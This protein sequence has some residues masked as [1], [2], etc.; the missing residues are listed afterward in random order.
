[1]VLPRARRRIRNEGAGL[2]RRTRLR[3]IGLAGS[4]QI[5]KP[6]FKIP[7]KEVSVRKSFIAI[8]AI[9]LAVTISVVPAFARGPGGGH[10]GG[11]GGGP[12][13]FVGASVNSA[14]AWRGSNP[15]GF[16]RGVKAG[17]DDESVPPGWSKGKKKGW[18]N[19][20]VPPG[21]YRR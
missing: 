7:T 1:V 15:P 16:S 8:S 14:P 3:H 20:T 17:W 4:G 13:A 6:S 9:A 18:K 11:I 10:G 2:D 19:Q 21:L 5:L 12:P